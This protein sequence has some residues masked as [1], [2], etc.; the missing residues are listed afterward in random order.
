MMNREKGSIILSIIFMTLIIFLGLSLLNFTI[1]HNRIVK[2]RNIHKSRSDSLHNILIDHL[3]ND[4]N[5]IKSTKFASSIDN[6]KDYFNNNTYPDIIDNSINVKKAFSFTTR[7]FPMFRIFRGIFE[8]ETIDSAKRHGWKS[9]SVFNIVSGDIPINIIPVFINPQ[10]HTEVDEEKVCNNLRSIGR[11]QLLISDQKSVFN[12]C[13]YIADILKVDQTVMTFDWIM[14]LFG[15]PDKCEGI[16]F[17]E[18]ETGCGPVFAHGEVEKIILSVEK[19]LQVIEIFSSKSYFRISYSADA[20]I[21]QSDN[22]SGFGYGS[23]N[24]KIII[25]GNVKILRGAETTALSSDSH[26]EF[27]VLGD[28]NILSSITG[29][30]GD[31]PGRPS[32]GITIISAPSPF[33]D[34]S[35]SPNLTF[36]S[37]GPVNIQGSIN[38]NGIINNKNTNVT[39]RGNLYCREIKNSG[40]IQVEDLTSFTPIS[41]HNFYLKDLSFIRDFRTEQ[42]EEYFDRE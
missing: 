13:A 2:A 25:N 26:P 34:K 5:K 16:Y 15:N 19:D 30:I 32:S 31:V 8:M 9:T 37:D 18:S 39:I 38:I 40:N 22:R 7:N 17:V 27:I 4:L 20:Y 11:D 14:E 12:I 42:I 36:L 1:I 24:Q 29:I 35:K 41:P 28:I 3:H 10:D 21:F 33:S 6:C 23:F